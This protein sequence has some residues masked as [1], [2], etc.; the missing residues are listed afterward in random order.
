MNSDSVA[1]NWFGSLLYSH[2]KEFIHRLF[3][4]SAW[5]GRLSRP[6]VSQHAMLRFHAKTLLIKDSA[7]ENLRKFDAFSRVTIDSK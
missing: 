5:I 3:I 2:R 6:I 1:K 7:S 4:H